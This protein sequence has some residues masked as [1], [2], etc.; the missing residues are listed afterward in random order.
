MTIKDSY[1]T[2]TQAAKGMNVSRQ[3]ISNWISEGKIQAET[4]GRE[5]LINKDQLYAYG[6]QYWSQIMNFHLYMGLYVFLG[7]KPRE[8][9][10]RGLFADKPAQATIINKRGKPEYIE[11]TPQFNEKGRLLTKFKYQKVKEF[12]PSDTPPQP[13]TE[14][15]MRVGKWG[16][17]VDMQI[18]D[19]RK[20]RDSNNRGDT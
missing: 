4:I 3:T 15:T 5:K 11:V 19:V 7:Y 13:D 6:K 12:S 16:E 9:Y 18:K 17:I 8:V 14:I 20:Y 10:I 2:I 1:F